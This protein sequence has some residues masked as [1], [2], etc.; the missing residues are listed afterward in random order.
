MSNGYLYWLRRGSDDICGIDSTTR[1]TC[2]LAIAGD[3]SA[4]RELHSS[5]LNEALTA[6]ETCKR[7]G[8]E[9]HS[10]EHEA[11][12]LLDRV[13]FGEVEREQESVPAY[14]GEPLCSE[15]AGGCPQCLGLST[16]ER[17]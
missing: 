13:Y 3:E 4:L 1:D 7:Y 6:L 11:R 15:C 9:L 8:C 16:Q 14:L 17:L 10:D 5:T 12:R 2:D